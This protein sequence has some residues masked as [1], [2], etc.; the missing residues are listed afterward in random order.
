MPERNPLCRGLVLWLDPRLGKKTPSMKPGRIVS[1]STIFY[2]EVIGAV[3]TCAQGI[4]TVD[5]FKELG[6]FTLDAVLKQQASRWLNDLRKAKAFDEEM[7]SYL[8]DALVPQA[9]QFGVRKVVTVVDV[10]SGGLL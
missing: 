5:Q 9:M 2:D 4:H 7:Q 3:M 1:E 8:S 10:G 6:K